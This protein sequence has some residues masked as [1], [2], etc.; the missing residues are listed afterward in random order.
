MLNI[1]TEFYINDP[2]MD[3]LVPTS[4][5]WIGAWWL[6]FLLIFVLSFS[7][8]SLISFFP[9]KI[10]KKS[11]DAFSGQDTVRKIILF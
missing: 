7:I 8:A 3:H 6:G 4:P 5:D 9:A 2:R 10:N 1:F 11:D